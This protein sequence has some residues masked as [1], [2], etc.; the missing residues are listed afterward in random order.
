VQATNQLLTIAEVHDILAEHGIHDNV[1][2]LVS[3]GKLETVGE[4]KFIRYRKESLDAFLA[5][6]EK[7]I[8]QEPEKGV[9][10]TPPNAQTKAVDR[11]GVA[12]GGKDGSLGASGLSVAPVMARKPEKEA[13]I[14]G[15]S[16][17]G[18]KTKQ[19]MLDDILLME[20]ETK[21]INA[22]IARDEAVKRRDKPEVLAKLEQSLTLR[23]A[24]IKAKEEAQASRELALKDREAKFDLFAI[25]NRAAIEKLQKDT[26]AE[27]AEKRKIAQAEID[28]L[29]NE[30]TQD[31][32]NLKFDSDNLTIEIDNKQDALEVVEKKIAEAQKHL[33]EIAKE[34]KSYL[35]QIHARA[36][37]H[38]NVARKSTG[39]AQVFHDE[40]ANKGWDLEDY[41]GKIL[42]QI[43]GV[44][45]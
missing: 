19:Q 13:S 35:P 11:Q 6:W 14:E 22:I 43:E 4:G 3:M 39:A 25:N 45:K 38:Y 27:N 31:F 28:S 1:Q 23:E 24:N 15:L 12:F 5:D 29:V 16:A 40:K 37:Q 30:A 26:E 21:H 10:D 32:K 9:G 17:E 34:A 33:D 18:R 36:V 42:K 41:I 2:G 7:A 20:V 44:L 8:N